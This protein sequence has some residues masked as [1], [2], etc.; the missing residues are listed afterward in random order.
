VFCLCEL[1]NQFASI[2]SES[3]LIMLSAST[4]HVSSMSMQCNRCPLLVW[5]DNPKFFID[6]QFPFIFSTSP[7]YS[8]NNLD[9]SVTPTMIVNHQEQPAKKAPMFITVSKNIGRSS[10][11]ETKIMDVACSP[12]RILPWSVDRWPVSNVLSSAMRHHKLYGRKMDWSSRIA[13]RQCWNT[14][15]AC[16]VCRYRKH[17]QVSSVKS[18]LIISHFIWTP[19]FRQHFAYES[20]LETKYKLFKKAFW[21]PM[22]I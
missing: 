9:G 7:D 2:P 19:C 20:S 21:F 10:N 4:R 3:I 15:M 11:F 18:L 17:M 14:G 8:L 22:L 12:W 5:C 16:A 1:T 6:S 13:I